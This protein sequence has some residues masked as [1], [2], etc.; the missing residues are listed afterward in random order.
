MAPYREAIDADLH[1]VGRLR[2]EALAAFVEDDRAQD[3]EQ[4]FAGHSDNC[5]T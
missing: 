3:G 2:Q 4:L 1:V 5:I